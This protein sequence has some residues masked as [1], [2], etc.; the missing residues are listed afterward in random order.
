MNSVA[1]VLLL[2]VITVTGVTLSIPQLLRLLRSRDAAGLSATSLLFGS[3]NVAA[4]TLYLAD[5][6]AWGL[7]ASNVLASLV[8]FAV[9]A[10]ALRALRPTWS[11]WLPAAWLVVLLAVILLDRPVLGTV[12]GLGSLLTY[13]P[14]ALRVW[15]TDTVS[16]ISAATWVITA[17]Q[18]IAWVIQSAADGLPGGIVSGT[19]TTLTAASVLTAVAVR[20]ERRGTRTPPSPVP[21]LAPVPPL[22]TDPDLL[23]LAA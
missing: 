19:V 6:R 9:V 14:Q 13:T 2:A 3:V 4:W 21:P 11:W 15:Q 12:L 20:R 16:G 1:S 10:L 7:V 5:A 23:D 18:S 22:G 17:V 8:W